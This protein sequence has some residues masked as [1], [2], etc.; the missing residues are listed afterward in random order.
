MSLG[1]KRMKVDTCLYVNGNTFISS[2]V[3]DL[4]VL[5]SD[6]S[7]AKSIVTSLNELI[8]LKFLG[9]VSMYLGVSI[10]QSSDSIYVSNREFVLS[11]VERFSVTRKFKTPAPVGVVDVTGAPLDVNDRRVFQSIVG[12]LSYCSSWRPDISYSV[13][14]VSRA[15]AAPTEVH[16][17]LARRIVGYLFSCD[18]GLWYRKGVKASAVSCYCDSDFASGNT[19]MRKSISGH[20]VFLYGSLVA[21]KSK[22]QPLVAQSSGEAELVSLNLACRVV[23]RFRNQ[24]AELDA[25]NAKSFLAE[26]S[27]V[28]CD[29]NAAMVLAKDGPRSFNVKHIAV[30]HFYV[31]DLIANKDVVVEYVQSSENVADG[32]TKALSRVLHDKFCAGVGLGPPPVV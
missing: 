18:L 32:F 22:S 28:R 9:R 1:F 7:T 13:G 30:R 20:C 21:F 17:E 27:V 19:A 2:Y 25:R 8:E 26:A 3:D 5:A 31:Q 4:L 12:C 29:N 15:V 6:E 10:T 14:F 23:Q 16:L 24:Y 11:L